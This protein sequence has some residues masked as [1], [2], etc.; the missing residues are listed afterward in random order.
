MKKTGVKKTEGER[1]E[2][3]VPFPSIFQEKKSLVPC[4]E[5]RLTSMLEHE[6]ISEG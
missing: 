1:G 4:L 2:G 3:S 6:K 5:A